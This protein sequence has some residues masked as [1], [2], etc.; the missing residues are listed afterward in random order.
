[1]ETSVVIAFALAAMAVAMLVAL[2]LGARKR[3][4]PVSITAGRWRP[5][6]RPA[7]FIM[8][9]DDEVDSDVTLYMDLP[10]GRPL[11]AEKTG[12]VDPVYLRW[13]QGQT[14]DETFAA[15]SAV[16]VSLEPAEKEKPGA[17]SVPPPVPEEALR[18]QPG[19]TP[20]GEPRS[21]RTKHATI[22]PSDR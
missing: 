15:P 14:A 17:S 22:R 11:E 3:K 10:H 21:P 16:T 20:F 19:L 18:R 8:P 13:L 2:G 1:M 12:L 6:A 5:T 9:S 7:P 4:N